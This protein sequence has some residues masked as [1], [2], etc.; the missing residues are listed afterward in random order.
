FFFTRAFFAGLLDKEDVPS[1]LLAMISAGE[2]AAAF[3]VLLTAK[4]SKREEIFSAGRSLLPEQYEE[5][6]LQRAEPDAHKAKYER[7]IIDEFEKYLEPVPKEYGTRV[8]SFYLEHVEELDPVIS[9]KQKDRLMY[10][11]TGSVF[12]N[13]DPASYDL[14][15]TSEQP[16]PVMAY[17]V[18]TNI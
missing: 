5:W 7:Q 13:I 3:A 10:L 1:Y 16:G 9:P 8:F 18:S 15:A 17:S 4:F 14:T 11:I 2:Q 6:E 12:K